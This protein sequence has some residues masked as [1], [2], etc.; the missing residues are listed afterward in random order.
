MGGQPF[1]DLDTANLVNGMYFVQLQTQNG[2][3]V[4]KRVVN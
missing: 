1:F 2:S 3:A 4:R